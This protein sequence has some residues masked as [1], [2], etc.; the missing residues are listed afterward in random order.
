MTKEELLTGIKAQL[1][2]PNGNGYYEKLGISARTLQSYVDNIGSVLPEGDLSDDVVESHIAIL[3]S[4]GGQMR[5]DISDG[6]KSARQTGPEPPKPGYDNVLEELRNR[7]AEL[8]KSNVELKD[9]FLATERTAMREQ[10]MSSLKKEMQQRGANDDYVLN[11]VLRNW[12]YADGDTLQLVIDKAMENYDAEVKQCRGG[13]A[14]PRRGGES[15]AS[16]DSFDSYFSRKL[17]EKGIE[18]AK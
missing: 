4:I 7:I 3:T 5:K 10:F 9:K 15:A 2:D 1:G 18:T 16:D 11:V 17:A 12:T 14:I 8:D 6:I 13:G